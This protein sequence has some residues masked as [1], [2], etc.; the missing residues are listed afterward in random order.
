MAL[1]KADL[2]AIESIFDRKFDKKFDEKFAEQTQILKQELRTEWG[3]ELNTSLE[4]QKREIVNDIFMHMAT[5]YV[6][7]FEFRQFAK[8]TEKNFAEVKESIRNLQGAVFG[9]YRDISEVRVPFLEGNVRSLDARVTKLEGL[10][11]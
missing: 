7:Q 11:K 5:K 9:M 10:A 3:T 8:A 6:T 1:T 2:Q 4:K